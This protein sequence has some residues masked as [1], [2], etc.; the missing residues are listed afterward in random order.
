MD[1]P[2]SILWFDNGM[3]M[4]FDAEGEQLPAYQG[5]HKNAAK[6]LATLDLSQCTFEICHWRRQRRYTITREEF[7]DPST[8]ARHLP[9][10]TAMTVAINFKSPELVAKY[11]SWIRVQVAFYDFLFT[12]ALKLCPAHFN[13]LALKEVIAEFADGEN[14]YEQAIAQIEAAFA[15]PEEAWQ[16][17]LQQEQSDRVQS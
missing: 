17:F 5:E 7:F 13:D 16:L 6:R 12:E 10:A 9:E 14:F 11:G 2:A 8:L 4:A 15:M 1:T 3:V